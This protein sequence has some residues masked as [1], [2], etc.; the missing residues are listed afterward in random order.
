M[1]HLKNENLV[2]DLSEKTSLTKEALRCQLES[3][4]YS[5]PETY[6][7]LI[8]EAFEKKRVPK[9]YMLSAILFSVSSAVGST[10][11][12]YIDNYKNYANSYFLV[13]GSR[14]D[15]KSEA[16]KLATK[17]LIHFDNK[18]FKTY[19]EEVITNPDFKRKQVLLQKASV[20]KA[21]SVLHDNSLGIG[22][23]LD[24][25]R[26]TFE[27][28]KNPNSRDGS[29]WQTLLLSAFTNDT[30][31]Y[32]TKTSGMFRV[33]NSY[34]T[35]F[36]GIQTQLLNSFFDDKLIYSGLTD[37]FLLTPNITSNRR[38]S[39]ELID[40][41]VIGQFNETI[42]S[43]LD[44]RSDFYDA[45]QE[46]DAKRIFYNDEAKELFFKY[47]Q[48]LADL[49]YSS[50]PPLREYYAKIS[51]YLHKLTLLCYLLKSSAKRAYE[52]QI[53][54]EDLQLAWKLLEFYVNCFKSCLSKQGVSKI[55]LQQLVS[56]AKSNNAMQK[57]VIDISGYSKAQVSKVW[58]KI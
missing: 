24:E 46:V 58:N 36:G 33:E 1:E 56:Y 11:Y 9:E 51:I 26:S 19:E 54:L 18:S 52:S 6:S 50:A 47:S 27:N 2:K 4:V 17:P 45:D 31:D 30:L 44:Y 37:R 22:I 12:T 49:K 14:G 40:H 42:K 20:E 7:K 23:R 29:E 5:L 39:R 16:L 57:S 8:D 21:Y 25:V 55:D 28:I 53:T 10:F 43:L 3:I 38:I 48:E 34:I 32:A 13:V 41:N 35:F 15:A